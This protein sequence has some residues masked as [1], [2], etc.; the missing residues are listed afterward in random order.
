MQSDGLMGN[1]SQKETHSEQAAAAAYYAQ[2]MWWQQA[3][4]QQT[5]EIAKL[6]DVQ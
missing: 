3:H 4:S 1:A 2:A 6:Q 5:Y